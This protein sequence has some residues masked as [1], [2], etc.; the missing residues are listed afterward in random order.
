MKLLQLYLTYK[1]PYECFRNC[2]YCNKNNHISLNDDDNEQNLSDIVSYYTNNH[3]FYDMTVI[4][5]VSCDGGKYS[6]D[7]LIKMMEQIKQV[8]TYSILNTHFRFLSTCEYITKEKLN[9]LRNE[10]ILLSIDG[11]YETM[12][13]NRKT[14]KKEWKHI[15]ELIDY[16]YEN[17]IELMISSAFYFNRNTYD[18]M[19][20]IK[21]LLRNDLSKWRHSI[22]FGDGIWTYDT[23]D[24]FFTDVLRFCKEVLL[25]NPIY[26]RHT[27]LNDIGFKLGRTLCISEHV[28]GN[29][30]AGFSTCLKTYT[31]D[32][33]YSPFIYQSIVQNQKQCDICIYKPYCIMC[34]YDFI[35]IC[36]L[37]KEIYCY[38]AKKFYELQNTLIRG[39]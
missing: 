10:T 7:I 4:T 21:T 25:E 34:P 11:T 17:D 1:Q 2:V 3:M 22:V 32:V 20:Y 9:S 8:S 29:K 33:E 26:D 38:I 13:Q 5:V 18:D 37:S 23:I 14:T 35:S 12:Q 39:L 19:K 28:L 27:F 16:V 36:F 15:H 24:T 30:N 31:K 6:Y